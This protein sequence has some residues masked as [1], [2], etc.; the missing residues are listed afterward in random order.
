MCGYWVYGTRKE[1]L[2]FTIKDIS[3]SIPNV[4]DIGLRKDQI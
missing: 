4:V 3:S 1:K 2:V